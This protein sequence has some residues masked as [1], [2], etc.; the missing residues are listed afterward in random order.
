MPLFEPELTRGGRL[1]LFGR[2]QLPL[3]VGTLFL[4]VGGLIIVPALRDNVLL[5]IGG[6]V[7]VISS[8]IGGL[9]PW[10]RVAPQLPIGLAVA[11]VLGVALVRAA[12]IPYL[13]AAEILAMFPVLWLAYGFSRRVIGAA[14]GAT[15]FISAFPYVVAW[16][17]PQSTLEWLNLVTVPAFIVGIALLLNRA[18]G[19]LRA[20]RAQQIAAFDAQQVALTEARDSEV[21]AVGILDA[22]DAGVA[23]F[24]AEGELDIAND[25]A[26]A[27]AAAIGFELDQR[28]R[29]GQHMYSSDRITPVPVAEQPLERGLG[30][31]VVQDFGWIGPP[32]SQ[33][34][35][36]TSTSP[37]RRDSGEMLGTVVVM[38]DVTDLAEALEIREEFLRTVSHELRTPLTAASGYLELLLDEADLPE[39]LRS[40]LDTVRRGITNLTSRIAELLAASDEGPV[41]RRSSADLGHVVH[42]SIERLDESARGR[43]IRF[44]TESERLW[45]D[46]DPVRFGQ[47]IEELLTNAIKFGDADMPVV[48]RVTADDEAVVVSVSDTGPGLTKAESSRAFDRFYRAPYAR[49]QAI[50]G[51]GLGLHIVRNIVLAHGGAIE[52]RSE[53]RVGTT[54]VITLPRDPD[55]PARSGRDQAV[56]A[57]GSF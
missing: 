21:I 46:I 39:R 9:V 52:L 31:E 40:R 22:V 15:F 36:I 28:P 48:V 1:R 55:A 13:A 32:D 19:Q 53:P 23:F 29:A 45:V 56:R 41:L 33:L 27:C 18:A 30:G 54:A 6:A 5:Y 11:D 4:G 43:V 3:L 20:S 26:V 12:L 8:A 47:A 57:R 16:V 17:W 42:E 24:T 35:V 34:A 14:I 50:Q 25:R 10:E 51:F 2:A 37:V 44:G 49:V 38:Y 7:I